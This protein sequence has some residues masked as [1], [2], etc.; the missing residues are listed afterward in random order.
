MLKQVL[1]YLYNT[2][3]NDSWFVGIFLLCLR[4]FHS[5]F[6]AKHQD[7]LTERQALRVGGG[8]NAAAAAR[9]TREFPTSSAPVQ[10]LAQVWEL[11]GDVPSPELISFLQEN[12]V[13]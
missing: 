9:G 10:L 5:C 6:A 4:H 1:L 2:N 13:L 7:V 12:I 8:P 11:S 3:L